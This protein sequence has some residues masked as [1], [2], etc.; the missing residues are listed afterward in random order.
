MIK[1]IIGI[2]KPVIGII[3][4]KRVMIKSNII[5]NRIFTTRKEKMGVTV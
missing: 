2:I 1:S 3:K 4:S 5:L